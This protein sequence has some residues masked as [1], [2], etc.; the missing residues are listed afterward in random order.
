MYNK[1]KE[2]GFTVFSVSLDGIDAR[3]KA[4]YTDDAQLQQAM[5]QSKKNWIAAIEKDQLAWPYHVSDLA[6]WDTQAARQYGVNSIPRTF[7]IDREGK[8]AAV[9][10][11]FTLEEELLKVL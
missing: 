4:R 9:N 1:Y 2:K 8:I 11:R 6:K 10:P 5:E 7:L 3:T